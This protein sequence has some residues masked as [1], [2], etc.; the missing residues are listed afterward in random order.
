M[1]YFR[2]RGLI[3]FFLFT[4]LFFFSPSL[5]AMDHPMVSP[6]FYG[7]FIEASHPLKKRELIRAL[8]KELSKSAWS[9]T[10]LE[11]ERTR[12]DHFL[13]ELRLEERV[14]ISFGLVWSAARRLKKTLS[15]EFFD[16]VFIPEISSLDESF[17]LRNEMFLTRLL[18]RID[19]LIW[20]DDQ[21]TPGADGLFS[22]SCSWPPEERSRYKLNGKNY[23]YPKS[24]D[25]FNWPER[26]FLH[27]RKA[28]KA[29]GV[30]GEGILIGH[31]DVGYWHHPEIIDSIL[32]DKSYNIAKD[33]RDALASLSGD[34]YGHGVV[35]VSGMASSLGRQDYRPYS[36]EHLV[37][38]GS[39]P[40]H[41]PYS[42]GVAPGSRIISYNISDG[43]V[44]MYTFRNL[45]RAIDRGIRDGVGVISI[46]LGGFYPTPWLRRAIERA[47]REGIII[48]AAAGNYLSVLGMAKFITWPAR[49]SSVI[50]VASSD[51][52]GKA[53]RHSSRGR[54]IDITAPGAGVW[55]ATIRKDESVVYNVV[56]RSAGTSLATSFVTGAA[57]LFLSF[58]GRD[59]L[60]K[61]YGL[62][63][64]G[65]VFRYML[66]HHGYTQPEGWDQKKYGPGILNVYHLLAAPLPPPTVFNQNSERQYPEEKLSE[67]NRLISIFPELENPS[68]RAS[69]RRVLGLSSDQKFEQFLAQVGGELAFYLSQHQ[70]ELLS[71]EA[72]VRGISDFLFSL[73]LSEEF[74]ALLLTAIPERG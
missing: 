28:Q 48:V 68:V 33:S 63:R 47:N 71:S 73:D 41:A 62:S 44:V 72:G 35:T 55:V 6:R 52:N 34:F 22:K 21:G 29:F 64:I 2:G 27:A 18:K 1:I 9:L 7:F 60:A 56:T 5:L 67:L 45:T 49:Y 43:D 50:A 54:G 37:V 74:R 26:K 58:H 30:D 24:S 65:E 10:S 36:P 70:E 13:Y 40:K 53:W 46:S 31:P 17:G 15:L 42:E 16:P 23:C 51:S 12:L 38:Y 8:P 3:G 57:S 69:L 39:D 4:L 11:R 32:V 25:S 59:R 20:G 19:H 66:R 61:K 14:D